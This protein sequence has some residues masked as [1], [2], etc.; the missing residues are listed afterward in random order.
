MAIGLIIF[1][2]DGVIADSEVLSARVL[3]DQLSRIGI[4]LTEQDV[5]RDFLGRSFPTVAQTIRD[6]FQRPLPEDFEAIY[7]A[8]LLAEF[9][10]SL[11]PTPGFV[12]MLR[13]LNRPFCVATSSSPLRVSRTL[14][15]LGL[16]ADFGNNVFTASQ[17]RHGKPA[18]DLFLLAARRMG[19]APARCLVVEDSMPGI[20]AGLSAGMQVLSYRG[21]AHLRDQ[22]VPDLTIAN[23]DK[24]DR[25]AQ[26]LSDM[27][28]GVCQ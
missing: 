4:D 15:L 25:F 13:A 11:Q 5:T 17:V 9:E 1:D 3:I 28:S 27:D 12:P 22:P 6:R 8:R 19:V 16:S 2:C 14:Q 21:G 26:L 23:F 10:R 18:P 20:Q 24:W 7:R